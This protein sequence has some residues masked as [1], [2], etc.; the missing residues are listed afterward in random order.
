MVLLRQSAKVLIVAFLITAL[1]S[2]VC[3]A[4][5]TSGIQYLPTQS[6]APPGVKVVDTPV[7]RGQWASYARYASP[8]TFSPDGKWPDKQVVLELALLNL[9]DPDTSVWAYKNVLNQPAPQNVPPHLKSYGV[10]KYLDRGW[11]SDC[12]LVK[13]EFLL[14][15]TLSY[16]REMSRNRLPQPGEPGYTE[17]AALVKWGADHLLGAIP[18]KSAWEPPAT[19]AKGGS[20]EKRAALQKE[21]ERLKEIHGNLLESRTHIIAYRDQVT[22]IYHYNVAKLTA[23]F[24]VA[25]LQ[26]PVT[27]PGWAAKELF[28]QLRDAKLLTPQL[29]ST[30][31]KVE[32]QRRLLRLIHRLDGVLENQLSMEEAKK[33]RDQMA[34]IQT[35]IRKLPK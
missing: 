21:Y 16:P 5:S 1:C 2:S 8:Y 9:V 6:Q 17:G 15:V 10:L 29:Q 28:Q 7:E 3:Q 31:E 30:T 18:G 35:E 32:I 26:P 13:G 33:I 11:G 34:Q 12:Y 19:G 4:G 22:K 23:A 27:M 20:L 14:Q 24:V 25:R